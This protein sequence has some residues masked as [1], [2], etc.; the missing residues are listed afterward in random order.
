MQHPA[1]SLPRPH[2]ARNATHAPAAGAA[3]PGTLHRQQ[4]QDTQGAVRYKSWQRLNTPGPCSPAPRPTTARTS[5]PRSS[6][7]LAA[8]QVTSTGLQTARSAPRPGSSEPWQGSTSQLRV[9]QAIVGPTAEQQTPAGT[10]ARAATITAHDAAEAQRAEHLEAE[11][12]E[13]SRQVLQ[14]D[15]DLRNAQVRKRM[16]SARMTSSCRGFQ[17]AVARGPS[18]ICMHPAMLACLPLAALQN[19]GAGAAAAGS[20]PYSG[21]GCC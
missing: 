14:L 17:A 10:H 20:P 5:W 4:H 6:N 19:A 7:P 11:H 16:M 3:A 13:V 21:A 9:Q 8:Q 12:L 18:V 2:S 1:S 15:A